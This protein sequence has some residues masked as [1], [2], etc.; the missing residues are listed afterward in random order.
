MD[1]RAVDLTCAGGRRRAYVDSSV[2]VPLALATIAK[3][4]LPHPMDLMACIANVQDLEEQLKLPG[5]L[6]SL[7][8][9]THM[10]C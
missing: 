3:G 6:V 7:A 10:A 5:M 9:T 1:S 2:L 4:S 8:Y